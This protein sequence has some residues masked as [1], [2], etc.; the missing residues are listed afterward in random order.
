M[1]PLYQLEWS[2]PVQAALQ[3][4]AAVFMRDSN[5]GMM[6]PVAQNAS[7]KIIGL[8]RL[9]EAVASP[10][11]TWLSPILSGAN[12]LATGYNIYQNHKLRKDI[13]KLKEDVSQG[14]ADTQQILLVGLVAEGQATRTLVAAEGKQ[15]RE[16]II[17]AQENIIHKLSWKLDGIQE[18]IGNL[19]A[20]TAYSVHLTERIAE[21][22]VRGFMA[23]LGELEQLRQ[24]QYWL[25]ASVHQTVERAAKRMTE[26]EIRTAVYRLIRIQ[27]DFSEI[28]VEPNR[29][30]ALSALDRD[31]SNDVIPIFRSHLDDQS[32]LQSIPLVLLLAEAYRIQAFIRAASNR[33]KPAQNSLK[34]GVSLTQDAIKD[35]LNTSCSSYEFHT[36]YSPAAQLLLSVMDGLRLGELAF[37]AEFEPAPVSVAG[38][39]WDPAKNRLPSTFGVN[40]PGLNGDISD[41]FWKN[42]DSSTLARLTGKLPGSSSYS[43]S[44]SHMATYI[45]IPETLIGGRKI[46]QSEAN[47]IG[48]VLL[49]MIDPTTRS[50]E[51]RILKDAAGIERIDYSSAQKE[52]AQELSRTTGLSIASEHVGSMASIDILT[53]SERSKREI[54]YSFFEIPFEFPPNPALITNDSK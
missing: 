49:K 16:A 39:G 1:P 4:G 24:G 37:G 22:Q 6:L 33:A 32:G 45:G 52:A 7:G 8:P 15:T 29:M 53:L 40:W 19:A 27:A 35:L 5:S 46:D 28:N 43:A 38:T 9:V 26:R 18:A 10:M 54:E 17:S 11:S 34:S 50:V 25:A 42:I 21:T 12:L 47:I 41:W 13:S 36:Q 31:L 44:L 2:K 23:V 3:N 14:F 20:M 51:T 30:E 48:S